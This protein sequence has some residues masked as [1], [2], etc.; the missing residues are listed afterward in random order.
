LK[1]LLVTSYAEKAV[2]RNGFLEPEVEMMTKPFAIDA[3][4][5]KVSEMV[6]G[7]MPTLT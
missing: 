7:L 4:A 2:V 3:L 1:V 6:T 5:T